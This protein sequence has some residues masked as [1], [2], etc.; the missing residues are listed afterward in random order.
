MD[1][2]EAEK[3]ANGEV[4]A[5]GDGEPDKG[6]SSGPGV[7]A[8]IP[9]IVLGFGFWL[10]IGMGV[11]WLF[12]SE[13]AADFWKDYWPW[14]LGAAAV[15]IVSYLGLQWIEEKFTAIDEATKNTIVG[16]GAIPFLMVA[17]GTA[18]ILP[19]RHQ[20]FVFQIV[21]II[22]VCILPAAA[23][24][25][26]L[27]TRRP[28]ILNEFIANLSR[29]GLLGQRTVH[30]P[31]ET[32]AEGKSR[33]ESP[34]ERQ[35]RIDGYFQRFESMYGQLRFS[36]DLTRP[37]FTARLIEAVDPP[38]ETTGTG[39]GRLEMPA[40]GVR[41]A[42]IFQANLV[43][44]LGLVTVLSVIGWLLVLQPVWVEG[45]R[46]V[47]VGATG[48]PT[49]A[50]DAIAAAQ[51]VV[52]DAADDS[53][54]AAGDEDASTAGGKNGAA[55]A[56]GNRAARSAISMI[57]QSSPLNFAFLGAYFFGLQMLF[58]RFVSRDLGPNAYLA[59]AVRI[60][61]ANIA[62]WV[63]IVCLSFLLDENADPSAPLIAIS[64][65]TRWPAYL[66]VSAFVVG[67]F[68][69][70]LW[71]FIAALFKKVG[72]LN[73]VVPAT[74][75]DQPLTTLNGLTIWHEARL[76]EEDVE[77]V[78]NMASVDIVDIMLRTQIPAERLICWI[79]QAILYSLLGSKQGDSSKPNAAAHGL[80][81][82]G[83]RTA[84]Q[85]V[86]NYDANGEERKT[87]KTVLKDPIHVIVRAIQ[88]EP[89]FDLVR[90]WRGV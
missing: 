81:E 23:Y 29:L 55:D 31:N 57:P 60:I 14:I 4:G 87:L 34:Q 7:I 27:K 43:I 11:A 28:S 17:L 83:V 70:M 65:E 46:N 30:I 50:E 3:N 77:N 86:A 8:A 1:A 82:V 76:Q 13:R 66:L 45:S 36:G 21:F 2:Q 9:L 35:A 73:I 42:D 44:P 19:S 47:A 85:L 52:E 24:Y 53:Q 63:L 15:L 79:D 72:F 78:P 84:S 48:V 26:F 61:L 37:G 58:R 5:E 75:Q 22:V 25:L 33:T 88:L 6:S 62:V 18:V 67:V 90:A 49:V 89:N 68:P 56:R 16:F 74:E 80:R 41:I 64:A 39:S 20:E 69:R 32:T 12:G 38:K 71:Q 59:F 10:L 54:D 51:A 40:A